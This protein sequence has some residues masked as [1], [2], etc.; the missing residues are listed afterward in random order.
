[1]TITRCLLLCLAT[2][3]TGAAL[4]GCAERP[5]IA[6]PAPTIDGP[7][8]VD[9]QDQLRVVVFEQPSLS[10]V[11]QVSQ[12]GHV[13]V[14][15]IGEVPVRGRTTDE[16]AAQIEAKLASSYLRDPDVSVEVATY[17]PFFVLGEVGNPGQYS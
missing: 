9:T 17:R 12:A 7:Y 8:R 10:N 15:L 5:P 6:N 13:S 2:V 4:G 14:P 11:Y 16:I 3:L 1:M